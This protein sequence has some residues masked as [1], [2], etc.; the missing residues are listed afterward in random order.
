MTVYLEAEVGR[1][2]HRRA[3]S[4][5]EEISEIVNDAVRLVLAEDSLDSRAFDARKS[6]PTRD[7]ATVVRSL[8]RQGR[9]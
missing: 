4:T 2:L 6:E 9:I 5:G 8:K 1:A 7:F 3:T